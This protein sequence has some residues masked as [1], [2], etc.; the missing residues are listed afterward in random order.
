MAPSSAGDWEIRIDRGSVRVSLPGLDCMLPGLP[1]DTEGF[2]G[3]APMRLRGKKVLVTGAG[4]FIGSHL[5]EALV[6]A[7]CQVRAMLHYDARADRGNLELVGHSILNELDVVRGD[8]T[9]PFFTAEVVKGCD[10]VFHLAALIAIPYSYQA[11]AAYVQTNVIGTLN[12]LQACKTGGVSRL[13]HTSTSECYGTARYTPIDEEHPLQ[14]QSPY[15]ASKIGA[16]KLA[17]S[18]YLSFGTPVATLRPFNTFGPRQSARA[19]VP[20]ILSQLLAGA[21]EL[22][23]GDP[24]PVRDL[25]YVLNT[26]DAYLRMAE[27]DAAVGQVINAG[28]GRGETIGRVAELCM[29]AVGRRVPVTI[30]PGRIRPEKSEVRALICGWKKAARNPELVAASFPGAGPWPDGPVYPGPSPPVPAQGVHD[31][32]TPV[33]IQ[34]GGKGTRLYPYTKVLPKP[35]MPVGGIPILDIVIRQLAYYGFHDLNITLGYLGEMIRLCCGNGS[36]WGV[37]IRYWEEAAPLGTIGPIR[38]IAGLDRPFLVLNGDL[39]T[40]LDFAAFL[41][42]H[43]DSGAELS[44]ATYAKEV[45]I[46]LGVMEMD[47]AGRVTGFE[48]KPIRHFPCSMGVYAMNPS[49]VDIVPAD[50][51]FGFDDL[52][53]EVLRRGLHARSHR[54]D[55]T[56]MDIG[57]PEDLASACEL[58]EQEPDRFT[59]RRVHKRAG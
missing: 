16:D 59:P 51:A 5:V 42:A 36:K 35:L 30:D 48:E 28:S 3:V 8:I 33:V 14:G 11:P 25:N 56:W 23:L 37:H 4:G 18:F 46:S 1:S 47:A 45:Q 21:S 13:I 55:G 50:R 43:L 57:R 38:H 27:C 7:G 54:F 44:I 6:Q 39:L 40:D 52:M 29:E 49:L 32:S 9:D 34:A 53:A 20:T 2:P 24:G 15:S 31:M 58:M 12:V 41:E 26:V 17:E 10:V 22:R 19:V